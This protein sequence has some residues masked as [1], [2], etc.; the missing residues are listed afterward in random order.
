[1]QDIEVFRA[2]ARNWLSE[3]FPDSLIGAPMGLEEADESLQADFET[4]R[5]RLAEKGWGADVAG[6]IWWCRIVTSGS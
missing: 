2:E 4:W 3:N 1:M 5:Q 6:G